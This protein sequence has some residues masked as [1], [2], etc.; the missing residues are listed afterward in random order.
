MDRFPNLRMFHRDSLCKALRF[1]KAFRALKTSVSNC[2]RR[3]VAPP[4]VLILEMLRRVTNEIPSN[5]NL[6]PK[7]ATKPH[8]PALH[9]FSFGRT[10]R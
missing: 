7:E 3:G 6:D 9:E 10:S 1:S 2:A 8:L 4:I 5:R